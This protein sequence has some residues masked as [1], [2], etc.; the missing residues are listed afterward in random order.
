MV[1]LEE[2][3][4]F[5]EELDDGDC[6]EELVERGL[7]DDVV[8]LWLEELVERGWLIDDVDTFRLEELLESGWLEDDVETLWIEELV[9]TS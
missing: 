5:C 9:E 1:G 8:V 4:A 3:E 6:I 7:L 2:L